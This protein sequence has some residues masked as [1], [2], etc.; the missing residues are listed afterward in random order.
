MCFAWFA[1]CFVVY[2]AYAPLR[3]HR[4]LNKPRRHSRKEVVNDIE[5]HPKS[6]SKVMRMAA[7]RGPR[8][9][10][11]VPGGGREAMGLPFGSPGGPGPTPAEKN[12]MG[13]LK[14]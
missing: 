9:P 4:R 12:K 3:V 14:K 6:V 11:S 5:R 2:F 7:Q 1:C 13:S 8:P 10:F